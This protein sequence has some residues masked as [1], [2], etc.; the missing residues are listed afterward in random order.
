MTF[1]LHAASLAGLCAALFTASASAAPLYRLTDLGGHLAYAINQVGDV[2]GGGYDGPFLYSN[3]QFTALG[4]LGGPNG[5]AF[6]LNRSRTVVGQSTT[7]QG[8]GH[9]FIDAGGVMTDLGALA[10]APVSS[11]ASAINDLGVVAGYT[12]TAQTGN[13]AFLSS[14]GQLTPLANPAGAFDGAL[15]AIN[16]KGQ[17]VGFADYAFTSG[18]NYAAHAAMYSGGKW[19]KLGSISPSA[20]A[21]SY[22]Q[23]INDKGQVAG[24]SNVST[25]FGVSHAFLW[26]RGTMK[27]LGAL[28]DPAVDTSLGL[29]LNNLGQVVGQ[30]AVAGGDTH[31]FVYGAQGM[32]D[33]NTVVDASG[34]GWTLQTAWAINDAG[35]IVGV[36]QLVPHGPAHGF[37]LTPLGGGAPR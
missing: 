25:P 13:V 31:A 5:L 9:A 11:Q 10:G 12:F 24:S 21:T 4:S 35:Q 22:A 18:N 36:G 28:G 32:V 30:S 16:A 3:G 2:A 23:A 19:K 34:L 15:V 27:D 20:K 29:G 8:V 26:T 7:A 17:A 6:G 1:R 37:L 14:N 33:L